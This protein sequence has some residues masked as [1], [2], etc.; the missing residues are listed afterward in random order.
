MPRAIAKTTGSRAAPQTVLVLQGGGA[1]GAY[2]GG[3]FEALC[4]HEMVPDWVVG[5]SIGAINSAI[6]AGNPP[7]R[8]VERLREFWHLVGH[9]DPFAPLAANP[10]TAWLAPW[11]GASGLWTTLHHGIPGFFEPRRR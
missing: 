9:D 4:K 7:E 2:Q 1:L 8:R 6:I 10:F 11:F 3:V 5:T